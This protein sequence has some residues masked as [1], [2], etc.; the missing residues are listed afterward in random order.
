[1][2]KP[3]SKIYSAQHLKKLATAALFAAIAYVAMF[4]TS[5]I[6]VGF[7]TFDAKDTIITLAGLLFG[8]LYS[9]A[10]SL[11]VATIELITVGDTGF[12]GFFM[13]FLSSAVF[14]TI[15]ALIYKYKKNIKGAIIGLVA[16]VL[17]MTAVMLLFNLFITP[18]YMH[19]EREVVA[20]MIP[21]LFLPFN[22]TKGTLN[23]ALVLVLYK[24]ISHALKAVKVLP[25]TEVVISD[26]EEKRE[27]R[28][29]NLI[30]SLIVTAIGIVT[31]VLCAVVFF[32][33][34]NGTITFE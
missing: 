22:L 33:F 5:W 4:V 14:S 30:F 20:S 32:V 8:P 25:K 17:T 3:N 26:E 24:P 19:V 6:K 13:N 7:L 9:L 21:T 1:M 23:A 18:F 16:S 2:H 29:K 34:L 12:Y 27:K 10:I 31:V 11:V 15:C 28:R